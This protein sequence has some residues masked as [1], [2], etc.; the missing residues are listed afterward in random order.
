[1]KKRTTIT[2]YAILVVFAFFTLFPFYW[3]LLTSIKKPG[4]I[5]G[6]AFK[7][8]TLAPTIESYIT[9]FTVKPFAKYLLNSLIIAGL[10]TLFAIVVSSLTAYAV[11]RLKFRGKSIIL[12]LVLAI[13]MFPQIAIISPIYL[14]IRNLGLR[15]SYPGLIIPYCAFAVPMAVWYL[16]AFFKTIPLSLEEAGKMDGATPFQAFYKI[17]APLA[18]PGVFTTAILVFISAWNEY[19]FSYTINTDDNMRTVPVGITMYAGQYTIPY[20]EYAAGVVIVTI[21]LV[22]MVLIFQKRIVS[23]LTSGAVKG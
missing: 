7:P 21:P 22:I 14:F 6:A 2:F 4:D 13:S 18:A 8:Y 19:L 20:G 9:V 5:F 10:T 11:A 3:E 12:G 16:S 1:M 17:I 23:G 15:N